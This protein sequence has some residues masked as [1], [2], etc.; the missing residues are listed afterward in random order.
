MVTLNIEGVDYMPTRL[1][2]AQRSTANCTVYCQSRGYT[3]TCFLWLYFLLQK[4]TSIASDRLYLSIFPAD[5]DAD[6]TGS[7]QPRLYTFH[8]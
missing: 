3:L 1:A 8:D 2:A 5:S 7:V 4:Q 6:A